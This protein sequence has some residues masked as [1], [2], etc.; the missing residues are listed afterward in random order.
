MTR[1]AVLVALA[2]LV[3]ATTAAGQTFSPQVLYERAAPAV[4]LVRTVQE[5]RQGAGSAFA[6]SRDGWVVTAAHVVRRADRI[7][8]EFEVGRRLRAR[9]V[10]YDARRDVALLRVDA[11]GL[12]FLRLAEPGGLQVGEPVA[13]IGNPRG[14]PKVLTTGVL[15]DVGLTLP[16][17]VPG[18][19]IRVSAEVAPGSS[20]GPV[21]T[22]RGDVAGVVVAVSARPGAEGGLAVSSAAVAQVL[23]SLMAG[24][25]V[26]RAW[27]GILGTTVTPE[28]ARER[29]LAVHRGVLVVEVV[30]D[31]P[32]ERAGLRPDSGHGAP[33]DV[34]VAL[35]GRPVD[36]MEDLLGLLAEHQPGDR[37]RLRVV[38]GTGVV[39]VELVLGVRP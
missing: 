23:P 34:I 8:V 11:T 17:L 2:V 6:I 10:G 25:R 13:V 39:D 1:G 5:D 31:A 24:A 32:A 27:I 9:L 16:G 7:S 26:E 36:T 15:L 33:G 37:V 14:R 29:G 28:L 4:A 19:L 3:A 30:A 21:L 20:G 38:R 12:A 22:S 35:N 18:I